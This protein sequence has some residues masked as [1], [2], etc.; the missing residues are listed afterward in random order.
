MVFNLLLVALEQ[1]VKAMDELKDMLKSAM[2][3]KDKTEQ[4]KKVVI[5]EIILCL[6]NCTM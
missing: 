6:L 3:G 5:L 1:D 4:D 2:R